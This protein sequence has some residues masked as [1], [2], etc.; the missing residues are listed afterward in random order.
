MENTFNPLGFH[1]DIFDRALTPEEIILK[2]NEKYKDYFDLSLADFKVLEA[3]VLGEKD[4]D[5][6]A[7]FAKQLGVSLIIPVASDI[8]PEPSPEMVQDEKEIKNA[9][10]K[11]SKVAVDTDVR[12]R[13][14]AYITCRTCGS[15]INR[16]YVLEDNLCPVCEG[17]LK[18]EAALRTFTEAQEKLNALEKKLAD[19]TEIN[20]KKGIGK[21]PENWL[22]CLIVNEKSPFLKNKTAMEEQSLI[23]SSS[24]GLIVG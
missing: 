14:S 5:F 16:L 7:F 6:A 12:N 21:G 17:T 15:S 22:V 18:S 10:E 24:G 1:R 2:L 19:D 4:A 8:V 11:L 3:N 13:K 20:R 23:P 9:E